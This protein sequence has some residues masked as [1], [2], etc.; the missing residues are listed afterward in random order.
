MD[1]EAIKFLVWLTGAICT[2]VATLAV[3]YLKL[4][5]S[6]AMSRVRDALLEV[7]EEHYVRREVHQGLLDRVTRLENRWK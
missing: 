7:L 3:I 1:W 2:S 6:Q 5:I 4:F